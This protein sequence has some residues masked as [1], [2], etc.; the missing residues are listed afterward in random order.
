MIDEMIDELHGEVY[1]S[2][3][4]FRLGYH[5]I[6]VR[7]EDIQKTT[8]RCHYGHYAFLV[9]PFGL[10]N[11]PSTFQ[12]CMNHIFNKKLRKFL[13][14]SF[15]NLLIYNRMWEE[16]LKHVDQILIIMEDQSLFSKEAKCEFG[17]KDILYLGHVIGVEV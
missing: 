16:H 14:V 11:A 5:Q 7:E 12:S 9:M 13:L 6:R 4:D 3:V 10:T 2:K 1:F 8:F 17:L 15:D